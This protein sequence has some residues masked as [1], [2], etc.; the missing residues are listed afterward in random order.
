M[1]IP[2]ET[3]AG[4]QGSS[5]SSSGAH[6]TDLVRDGRNVHERRQRGNP[7]GPTGSRGSIELQPNQEASIAFDDQTTDH[8]WLMVPALNNPIDDFDIQMAN[9]AYQTATSSPVQDTY[10]TISFTE[11]MPQY[12]PFLEQHMGDRY[13]KVSWRE[14]WKQIIQGGHS[15]CFKFVWLH[16]QYEQCK[17]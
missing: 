1:P 15:I 10:G 6:W 8:K 13:S 11:F 9:T 14:R 2:Q 12:E 17:P 3:A 5:S 16:S 4:A 7:H